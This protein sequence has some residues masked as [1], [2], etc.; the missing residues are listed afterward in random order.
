MFFTIV[1][2]TYNRYH[3]LSRL[4]PALFNQSLGRSE[5]EIIIV[6]D[7]S[8]D[9]SRSYL[10]NL[11]VQGDIRYIRQDH[12]GPAA[13][14][15][16]GAQ[17]AVGRYVAFTDDD[18]VVPDNWL[19]LW[20]QSLE[21]DSITI[22]G[23]VIRNKIGDS[24]LAELSQY[25]VTFL[26]KEY[27]TRPNHAI[28]LTSNNLVIKRTDFLEIGGF[29]PKF[30]LAGG[31]DREICERLVNVGKK[32]I[33]T[34]HIPVFHYHNFTPSQYCLQQMNYGQ[35]SFML[36]YTRSLQNQSNEM[37]P[38][39]HLYQKMGRQI[40]TD[41][42]PGNAL[43]MIVGVIV[44][45]FMVL[46]GF[47]RAHF[48]HRE[49]RKSRDEKSSVA[50]IRD[51]TGRFIPLILGG[52]L[53]SIL[54]VMNIIIVT[55]L[56]RLDQ[57]GLFSAMISLQTI[58]SC[59]AGL[60]LNISVVRH[61]AEKGK[62]IF[63]TAVFTQMVMIVLIGIGSWILKNPIL[64][65][66]KVPMSNHVLYYLLFGMAGMSLWELAKG[67]YNANFVFWGGVRLNITAFAFRTFFL[68]LGYFFFRP[69]SVIW[70]FI[71][72][73][74]SYWFSLG[75]EFLPLRDYFPKS[76]SFSLL[77]AWNLLS[78][79]GWVTVSRLVMI[80]LQHLPTLMLVYFK[81]PDQAGIYSIALYASFVQGILFWQV[82]SYFIPYAAHLKSRTEILSFLKNSY[83][84]NFLYGLFC[85]PH[86]LGAAV[87]IPIL[88]GS[89][90]H[91]AIWIFLLLTIC[92]YI[93]FFLIPV[94]SVF[95]YLLKPWILSVQA[96][97]KF[98]G[99][100]GLSLLLVSSWQSLGMGISV[101]AGVVI[102]ALYL[103][104]MLQM[105][106]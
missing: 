35:G 102:S 79:G 50:G 87:L 5:Y 30:N 70:I 101:L 6:D 14:R 99:Q 29:D 86:L 51:V 71:L 10:E 16:Q 41:F 22:A 74:V 69:D 75:L 44:S 18:C 32:V 76:W 80:I 3:Y 13:A 104:V 91:S 92:Q 56:F 26:Q 89:A 84:L 7:G 9:E 88:F 52:I 49:Y 25:M 60:G 53:H 94:Q 1:V 47:Y 8:T 106:R 34:P 61:S 46:C 31:E 98:I 39:L 27:N 11:Q 40:F 57:F 20:K 45:Q 64:A 37:M 2:P 12:Q 23:G 103:L 58:L 15:N 43:Q 65:I 81:A 78:Y 83:R 100:V 68:I 38:L 17:A 97:I 55:R 19:E 73:M 33:F 42:S 67:I 77:S 96:A 85:I 54:G 21:D 24:F 62:H 48:K 66:F 105:E 36:Y 72:Y 93:E 90:G 4:V 95:H 63:P 59:L 82:G 28:F